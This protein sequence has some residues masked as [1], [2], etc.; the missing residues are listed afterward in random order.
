MEQLRCVVE[1]ITY[2]NG[3]N[4]YSVIRCTAKGFSD[5]VTVVGAMPDV[6]VGSVLSL[7]GSWRVD[8]RYGRQFSVDSFEETLP[9]TAYGI[10]KYLGSGLVRGI[11]P[12]YAKR[13]VALFGADTLSVIEESPEALLRVP[14]IG[15]VRLERIRESWAE[16]K[17]IKNI[18]IF[19]QA[20]DVSTAL[21][22]KI[23][24]RYGAESIDIVTENPYRL[25]DD[26]WGVGFRTADAIASR[27]GFEK[28]KYVRLRSGLIYT[29][30][31]LS[32]EGHCYAGRDQLVQAGAA[33]LEVGVDLLS[34]ALSEMI[35]NQDVIVVQIPETD[36]IAVYLPPFY[37]S[38]VGVCTRLQKIA[39]AAP[40]RHSP[41]Q[42]Q[43]PEDMEYDDAQLQAIRTAREGKVMILTGG[44]GTGKS[45]TTLGIIRAFAGLK[46]LLAAP[47]GRA[48]RRLSEVTGLEAKT[49]HRLLEFRPPEGC[50]RNEHNP[51]EGDVLIVDECSMVDIQLM[52]HLLRAVPDSMRLILVGDVDQLPSV[53]AGNV[54]RDLIDSR[55]LPV[56]TLTKIFRQAAASRIITNAHRINHGEFP[57]LSNARGTDFF[58]QS[59]EEP[60]KA[61]PLIVDLVQN[62]LP[63]YYGVSPRTIQVLTPMQRGIIGALSL[64][65]ALQAAVNPP[66]AAPGA[67]SL[68]ELRRGGYVFRPGDKIMQIRN[69]YDKEVFNGDIG[70]VQGIRPEDR[71]LTALF[72][73]RSVTYDVTELDE[74]VLA[75]ASTVHKSQGAEYPIVVMPVMMTH[76]TMLQRNLLYTG[77]TRAR[78]ALVLVGQKKAVA[79][80]VRNVTVSG[81]NT[82]L[83]ERLS[84]KISDLRIT[85]A[86]PPG[87]REGRFVCFDVETPNARN[88][89]M[90]AIGIAVV[91]NGRV[92]EEFFS[93]V[94]PEEPFD[95]FNTELTG[96]SAET[97]ATAPAFRDLWPRIRPLLSGGI[98]VAHNAL[99]DLGVLK[100]CL[101]SEGI[102]WKRQAPYLC[103]VQIGRKLLPGISHRLNDLCSYYSISL[104]HHKADSDSRA[105]AEILIRYMLSGLN[106]AA[107][108]RFFMFS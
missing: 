61:A 28:E 91:E 77:V 29:L 101:R 83:A 76:F 56:V 68:P 20:H 70:T 31:K 36:E 41:E 8:P 18:M 48:A 88:D 84:G 78:K 38:E 6:H 63:K 57:D 32:E 24:R 34:E 60:E 82:L 62:R 13:I 51:L 108:Q 94:N 23:F 96:I 14:G 11:G 21:A 65:Q 25:A 40:S 35:R 99:F 92:T 93:F 87:L 95:A 72:E 19:L 16:Q 81:R 71:T 80:C 55:V 67:E 4:G 53:G 3:E 22:A 89:R 59:V 106:T 66:A 5:L 102:C 46:I 52:Y 43:L 27:L 37:Y 100:K 97:V 50:R 85:D 75:Y 104:D 73:D 54:L 10:E 107:E 79:Y 86:L 39:A 105:C 44:P 90:S 103:T 69:N 42:L 74:L 12:L 2:Q 58:F 98:L 49:I 7:T 45:T 1:R 15:K 9:A 47:T 26:I 30:N 17:E 33:L 64:N